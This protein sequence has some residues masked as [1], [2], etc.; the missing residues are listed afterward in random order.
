M[1]AFLAIEASQRVG[2]VA[3]RDLQGGVHVEM[4]SSKSRHDD[5]LMPAID[6]LFRKAGLLPNDLKN[7]VVAV[8]N[9]PGGFTGLRIAVSTAKMLA[10]TL[11]VRIVAVPSAM[12]AAASL[13]EKHL[14]S[15]LVALAS[16]NES[17]WCTRLLHAGG[18]WRIEGEP[19]LCDAASLD[20]HGVQVLLGDAHLP[21]A[22]A[23]RCKVAGMAILEPAFDPHACL[24]IGEHMAKAGQFT[25]PLRLVPLYPREPEAVT[26]WRQRHESAG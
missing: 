9:G 21:P 6:R 26:L 17:A 23:E 1:A 3:L 8:S 5:D 12:V 16:K 24:V 19:G 20:L 4:F 25:D 15:V 18:H 11:G 10:E 2:G 14:S 7:G 13:E 22:F